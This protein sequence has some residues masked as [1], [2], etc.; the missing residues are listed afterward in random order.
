MKTSAWCKRE[1]VEQK[2][3]THYTSYELSPLNWFILPFFVLFCSSNLFK[4]A[5]MHR[6]PLLLI[7]N[8]HFNLSSFFSHT[9]AR[10]FFFFFKEKNFK[11]QRHFLG[12]MLPDTQHLSYL[13]WWLSFYPEMIWQWLY[14]FLYKLPF[15]SG[16]GAWQR[17]SLNYWVDY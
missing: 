3:H 15:E 16:S 14:D 13:S 12:H 10:F 1:E 17:S 6:L 2:T 5:P 11:K 8:V 9:F 7:V 4:N